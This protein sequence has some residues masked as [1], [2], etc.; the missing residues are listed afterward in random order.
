MPTKPPIVVQL[1]RI[2]PRQVVIKYGSNQPFVKVNLQSFGITAGNMT[3][4]GTAAVT[5]RL[6]GRN[7]CTSGF[8]ADVIIN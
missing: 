3:A 1:R 4:T 7:E 2:L 6:G 8:G 5:S